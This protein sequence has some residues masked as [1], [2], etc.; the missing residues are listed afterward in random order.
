LWAEDA[1]CAE[2]AR[3]GREHAER[4]GRPQFRQRLAEIIEAVA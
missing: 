2:L 1:L 4:W 3:K